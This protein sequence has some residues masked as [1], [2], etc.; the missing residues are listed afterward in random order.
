MVAKKFGENVALLLGC[1]SKTNSVGFKLIIVSPKVPKGLFTL[2]GLSISYLKVTIGSSNKEL[3]RE[4]KGTGLAETV[5]LV[6]GP[7]IS[8]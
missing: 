7:L 4:L 1:L 5:V 8:C 2:K 3:F 6:S